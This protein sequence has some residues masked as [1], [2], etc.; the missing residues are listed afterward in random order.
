[1]QSTFQISVINDFDDAAWSPDQYIN[2]TGPS[3]DMSRNK[4]KFLQ[5]AYNSVYDN[6]TVN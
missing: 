2:H 4:W 5:I 3:D 1:M 6:T